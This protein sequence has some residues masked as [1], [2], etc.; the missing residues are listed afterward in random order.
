M[1][2]PKLKTVRWKMFAC[3][4]HRENQMDPTYMASVHYSQQDAY[5]T[6]T[7]WQSVVAVEIRAK[8]KL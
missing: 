2:K 6:R 8:V 1:K 4:G 7:G 3:I 5:A